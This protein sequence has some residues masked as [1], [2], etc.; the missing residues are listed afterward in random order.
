VLAFG[1]RILDPRDIGWML[2]GPLGPDPVQ[3]WLGWTF[4]AR[5][6]WTLPPG[7]NP[8]YG[9]ELAASIFYA[10][11]IP[12]LAFALKPL[13]AWIDIPQYWGLWLAGSGA[14]QAAIAY[15]LL[16]RATPDPWAR[17]AGGALFAWMPMLLNRMGG[18]LALAGQ[19]VLLWALWLC[20]RGPR[21]RFTPAHWAALQATT[22]LIHSYLLAMT[23]ALWLADWLAQRPWRRATLLAE[24]ALVFGAAFA[25]LWASGFFV[26]RSGFGAPGYGELGL[27]ATALFDGTIWGAL[28]PGLPGL[29]H[30]EHGGSYLGAGV[31]LVLAA[32]AVAAFRERTALRAAAARHV[33][34]LL[35][36][37]AMLAFA[38]T[39]RPGV[40]GVQVTLFEPPAALLA[41]AGTLR[42]SE[43]FVWPLAYAAL[44]AA[45]WLA[46]RRW[47]APVLRAFLAGALL[48]QAADVQAG[49]ARQ[50]GFVEGAP[51]IP[52]E[53]LPDPFWAEAARHY[54][55]IRAV[56]A[57]NMGE[58]WE[59]L[60]RLA[61]R[62]G[63]A[64]DAVY[65]AR[66]D[67]ARLAA[68][69]EAVPLR[70]REGRFEPRTLYVLRDASLPV[71][72]DP[73]RDALLVVDGL[74]VLAPGWH[75]R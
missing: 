49:L 36:L 23:M 22:A 19:W 37:A 6:P 43:R 47:P 59:S 45:I 18:H 73:A 44:F 41:L 58:H 12:L 70:L 74:T 55:A 34:L 61:A 75:A 15:L 66:M 31:L 9:M 3:Y 51:R 38:V 29:R 32:G 68:L 16:G 46:A 40:A 21:T 52:A 25:A 57:A 71:A 64:T 1:P 26:L 8:D 72:L 56:P 13:A 30:G 2:A 4:F 60:A 20:L 54:R 11:I 10:D 5:S 65:L 17:A 33:W 24:P 67:S 27:D 62:H 7:L 63:L 42:A 48:L 28:L 35:G 50:R 39:H 69:A 14:L 53:R